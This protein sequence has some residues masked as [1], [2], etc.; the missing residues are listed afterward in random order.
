MASTLHEDC[1]HP[2]P[3]GVGR[4]LR[5]LVVDD[6]ADTAA[7]TAVLLKQ[8]GYDVGTACCAESALAAAKASPPDVVLMDIGLPGPDGYQVS[9]Q[10]RQLLGN[11]PLFIAVTGYGR[12]QD[13]QQSRD[14]GFQH[15]LVKPVDPDEL[16]T[17]L[18]EHARLC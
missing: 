1:P 18:Q 17:I 9:R 4:I 12:E 10:L 11:Q 3:V 2:L 5:V 7:T 16:R 8:Y 13:Y 15:H 6:Y 14:E